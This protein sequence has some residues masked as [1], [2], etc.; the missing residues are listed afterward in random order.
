MAWLARARR[1]VPGASQTLSKGPS[2][3]VEGAYPV[4][5]E[6]GRGCRVWDV[7]G[8]EYVDYIL[9]LASITLGYAYP[10]IVEAVARQLERGSIFSLPHPLEVEV[11]ERLAEVIPCAEMARF[12]KT[13]SE[14]DA[15]A[16]RVARAAT[17]R[18]E[19]LVCYHP[20]TEILTEEGF[21]RIYALRVGDRVATLNPTTGLLEYQAVLRLTSRHFRGDLVHFH[22]RRVDLLV[23]PDHHIYREFRDSLGRSTFRLVEARTALDRGKP[24]IMTAGA[25]WIGSPCETVRIPSARVIPRAHRRDR[26]RGHP[27]KGV[28][29]FESRAFL[30]FLGYYLTEGWCQKSSR[31]R[32][33][34][35]LAQKAGPRQERFLET[36]RTLG[37][38]PRVSGHHIIFASKDLWHFLQE[39]GDGADAK[40]IPAWVKR[41]DVPLLDEL[42]QALVDGD[43]TR[44]YNGD[45]RKFYSTSK[46]LVD[47]VCDIALKLG[48]STTVKGRTN[49]GTFGHRCI[50]YH[51]SLSRKTVRVVTP[52]RITRV[53][54]DGLVY[55]LTV[56]NHLVFARRKGK[57]LWSGNCGYHGWG[58]WY[59]IT[60]P[61]SKGIPKDSSRLVA[62]F[63]YNDLGSL[64]RTLDEHHGRVAAV[65][66]EPVLLEAP[67]PGFLAGVKAAAHRHGALLIFDEIVSGFRWA[68]GGAQEYFNVVPDLA[69]FGKG[70]AN[71]LPLAAVV[72]RAELMA[73]FEEIFVSSTFGGDALAL[74]ACRAT[75]E[76]YT[77]MPVIERLWRMGR[78]FQE[79]F[80]VLT[81]RLGLPARC[82]GY[83][84]HPKIVIDHRSPETQRLLMSLFLQESAARGVLFHFAGFNISYSHAE[85]DV[86][87]TLEACAGALGVVGEAL[88][89]GR[90]VERLRGKPYTEAFRRS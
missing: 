47:D 55:C 61:R 14:A 7:D 63:D 18:D 48:Y 88:A 70:M 60:T 78:R 40:R 89:D 19:V 73:E 21:R 86:D 83:P 56:P 87:E 33:E 59:A 50:I 16:V 37:F 90:I 69:V 76:T 38:R 25:Q 17:G 39:C 35:N 64:E 46:T 1:V 22:G 79:G 75:L 4:F 12:L 32:Y 11:A 34:I 67:A 24:I 3:F 42:F 58:D 27:T 9:G 66:M 41:L 2:M 71:G 81:D 85:A 49:G 52:D 84:V 65:I 53:P 80:T 28:T 8:N 20:D 26:G 13:G 74:A 15:A 44:N 45:P 23:T 10:P 5:L 36:V 51:V 62:P 54:Y 31:A 77:L 29:E 30:R 57:A 6:R 43:G 82:V 72:G 68:V